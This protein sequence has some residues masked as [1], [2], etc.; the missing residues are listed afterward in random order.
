MRRAALASSL[1]LAASAS[2]QTRLTCGTVESLEVTSLTRTK[3]TA[4]LRTKL[5]DAP[6]GAKSF[7][8]GKIEVAN[9]ALPAGQPA[10]V[11]VQH[12]PEGPE[13]VFLVDLELSR[14]PAELVA[15]LHSAALDVT[16]EGN[17]RTS[18]GAAPHPVCAA[19]VLRVG[20]SDIRSSGPVGQDFARFAGARFRGVTLAETQGEATIVLYNPFKFPLDIKDLVYEVRAGDRTVASGERHGLR[21]HAGRENAVDLPVTAG[22]AELA[23]ALAGAVAAGGRAEGRLVATISVKVGKDQAMTVPLSLPGAIQV[24]P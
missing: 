13:A 17:L 18:E 7:F 16:L 12:V 19:G 24:L 21:L 20:T 5:P 2:A 14:V 9:T 22:N 3:V 10:T 6:Q 23:V 15:R 8:E 1:L 11:L 4:F